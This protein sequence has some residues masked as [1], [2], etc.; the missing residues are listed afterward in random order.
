MLILM[1]LPSLDSRE[2]SLEL[3]AEEACGSRN[4]NEFGLVSDYQRALRRLGSQRWSISLVD[5]Y[6]PGFNNRMAAAFGSGF[7]F[8][9]LIVAM[10][11][12]ALVFTGVYASNLCLFDHSRSPNKQKSKQFGWLALAFA[13]ISFGLGIALL[14]VMVSLNHLTDDF[15]CSVVSAKRD[16]LNGV[17]LER[18]LSACRVPRRSLPNL[19]RASMK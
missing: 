1:L 18:F 19:R 10:S 16:T 11:C 3:E 6:S 17:D 12:L 2:A 9:V 4:M 7:V 8:L 15:S 5:Y 14:V 13:G